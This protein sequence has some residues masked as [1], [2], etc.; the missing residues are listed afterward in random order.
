LG[1]VYYDEQTK[2]TKRVGVFPRKALHHVRTGGGLRET[3][4]GG[5]GVPTA[6]AFAV[7]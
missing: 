4:G 5:T 2:K 1:D 3:D 7:F 6:A